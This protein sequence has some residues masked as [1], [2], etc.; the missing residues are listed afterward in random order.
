NSVLDIT[1][2]ERE[3][4]TQHVGDISVETLQRYMDILLL[5]EEN[6]SRS[7]NPRLNIEMMI[8]RM[9]LLEPLIPIDRIITQ[10]NSLTKNIPYTSTKISE[11]KIAFQITNPSSG[12]S[13]IIVPNN[14]TATTK[15]GNGEFSSDTWLEFK[16]TV[17]NLN[18]S[19]ARWLEETTFECFSDGV[20]T[21][22]TEDNPIRKENITKIL[23]QREVLKIAEEFFGCKISFEIVIVLSEG[24][25][26]HNPNADSKTIS[27]KEKESIVNTPLV[28]K[29][30]EVFPSATIT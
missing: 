9:A 26:Q 15:K 6:I 25:I 29:I 17:R 2:D 16:K 10:L 27:T 28:K 18:E 13:P 3:Q 7:Q 14:S 11:N 12:T 24:K 8:M 22:A 4:I 30:F 20:I 1:L 19:Y 5:E 21:V 23:K